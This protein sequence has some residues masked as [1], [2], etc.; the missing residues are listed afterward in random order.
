MG[1]CTAAMLA[2]WLGAHAVNVHYG[3]VKP[4]CSR[5]IKLI[6][7]NTQPDP[8]FLYIGDA[9]SIKSFL[10][11]ADAQDSGLFIISAGPLNSETPKTLTLIETDLPLISLY[12]TVHEHIQ[13]F[14]EWDRALQEVIYQN[15]GLQTM[16]DRAASAFN[17]TIILVSSGYK[18]IASIYDP[19]IEEPTATELKEHGYLSFETIQDI[20]NEE[21]VHTV[22]IGNVYEYISKKSNR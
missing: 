1:Y 19:D 21:S 15:A 8:A 13:A 16:L 17:A 2:R 4:E 12:N 3:S 6:D 18:H 22:G 20:Y 11:N 5:G 9:A 7:G 10:K 14:S